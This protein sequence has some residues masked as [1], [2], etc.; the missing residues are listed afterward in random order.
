MATMKT[1]FNGQALENLQELLDAG[2]DSFREYVE[3]KKAK[4]ESN[5]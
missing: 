1:A 5:E 4:I 2:F 3:F